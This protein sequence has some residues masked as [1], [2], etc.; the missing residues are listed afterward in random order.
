MVVTTDANRPAHRLSH[1]RA[2]ARAHGGAWIWLCPHH[3]GRTTF[4]CSTESSV[5]H[6]NKLPTIPLAHMRPNRH[7]PRNPQV[8]ASS[9]SGR[10]PLTPRRER[11]PQRP[12]RRPR[13]YVP[14]WLGSP[15][16]NNHNDDDDDAAAAAAADDDDALDP[17]PRSVSN[18]EFRGLRIS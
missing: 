18:F 12:P 13:P 17:A 7:V 8:T 2:H 6:H 15:C 4:A 3:C 1:A 14:Q 16:N 5:V 10:P 11:P 9:P